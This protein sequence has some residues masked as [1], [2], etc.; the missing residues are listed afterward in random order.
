[1]EFRSQTG[2]VVPVEIRRRRGTRRLKIS[3]GLENQIVA[4]VPLRVSD[5]EVARFIEKQSVW[6]ERQLERTP[7][8]LELSEW[9]GA[10]ASLSASGDC[11]AVEVEPGW[12][13]RSEYRFGAGGSVVILRPSGGTEASLRR[14]VHNFAS[15]ALQCRVAYQAKRLGLEYASLSVRDQSSRW[16]SCSQRRGLSLN[17]RLVL[18]EPELEDYVILHELAHLTEM[19]HGPRFWALLGEYDPSYRAHEAALSAV[20]AAVMRVGR[21]GMG[22]G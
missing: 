21:G 20:S 16:G 11:F 2:G 7:E 1:M 17:W 5:R 4:S 22:N 18:L 3:L 6:L 19:N 13:R 14:L 10:N 8:S 12:S 15:D 9:F